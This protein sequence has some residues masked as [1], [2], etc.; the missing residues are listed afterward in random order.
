[1][2]TA[3]PVSLPDG[4]LLLYCL[5]IRGNDHADSPPPTLTVS[6]WAEVLRQ[7]DDNGVIPLL[8]HQLMT[9][10]P[11]PQVPPFLLDRLRDAAL[12]SAARSLRIRRELAQ[13]LD[14]LRRHGVAAIVLKGGHLGEVLYESSALRTMCDLDVMVRRE[15]L[16]RAAGILTEL[17][18]AP[19]DHGVEEV[20]YA[21]HHH[22]RPMARSRGIRVEI[23]WGIVWPAAPF[24]VDI[25]GLW[26][27]AR[28][29]A[30]AGVEALVLSHEDL[31]LHLC[32]HAS[33]NSKFRIG[34]R[35]CWDILEVVR[36]YRD[37][38]DW[39][40]VVRR[41]HQWKIGKY[42]Y[43]TLRLVRDWLAADIPG[44][45]IAALE[46]P[47][48]P[49]EV[50]G[51]ARTCI[52]TSGNDALVSPSMATLW[53][54]G[55]LNAKFSVLLN[56]L[57]PSRAAMARIYRTPP[58]STRIFLYYLVRWADLLLRYGRRAWGLWRGDHRSRDE[59]RAV[60]ARAALSDWLRR[61]G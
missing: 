9:I 4:A 25:D 46:P 45:T 17:G 41:A 52:F 58:G 6:D 37:T 40:L 30:I 13:V 24:D 35:P 59:L 18:Y 50:V 56:T 16:A 55:K 15:E 21:Q 26:Q 8:Y 1:V 42:V 7:A 60:S 48:F 49:S 53:T 23:H 12:R 43:L 31:I 3:A 20:D 5:G 33:F 11:A 61:A 39:D 57:Y 34:L 51:W 36:H 10:V 2:T 14:A 27:R 29:S 32:L 28:H 54:P 47:G 38:V 44:G 19:Q 22:L